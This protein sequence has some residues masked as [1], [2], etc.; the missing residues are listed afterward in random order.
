MFSLQQRQKEKKHISK[1]NT[2]IKACLKLVHLNGEKGS[3][4]NEVQHYGLKIG[5]QPL[6][7]SE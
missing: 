6:Q 7:D 5:L 2:K 3:Q 4:I 1:K